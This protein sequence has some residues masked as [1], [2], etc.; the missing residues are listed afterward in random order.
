MVAELI[1]KS[2]PK[3]PTVSNLAPKVTPRESKN[4]AQKMYRKL[5]PQKRPGLRGPGPNP[6]QTPPNLAALAVGT[7]RLQAASGT[8]I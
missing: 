1:P 4:A 7:S 5:M 3:L 2:V 6:P 8:Y